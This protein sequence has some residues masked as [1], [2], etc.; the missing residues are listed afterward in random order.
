MTDTANSLAVD[1]AFHQGDWMKKALD[2]AGVAAKD[3]AAYLDVEPATVSRWLNGKKPVKGAYLKL[4]ALKTGVPLQYLET[5]VV[6]T[7]DPDGGLVID[8]YPV[9]VR[10][11]VRPVFGGGMNRFRRDE[12]SH[13]IAA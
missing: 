6:P 4:W 9:K 13:R 3:M 2:H 12:M 11:V 7:G 10:D 1:L 5:G 8:C